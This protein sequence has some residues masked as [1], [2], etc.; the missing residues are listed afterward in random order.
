[1]ECL[2]T[3]WFSVVSCCCGNDVPSGTEYPETERTPLLREQT[4]P[5]E[6]PPITA[7]PSGAFGSTNTVS[8]PGS[9]ES[10]KQLTLRV[11][12]DDG[13]DSS[14]SNAASRDEQETLNEVVADCAV[15]IIDFSK[16]D[17][18]EIIV[19]RQEI[20]QRAVKYGKRLSGPTALAA[21]AGVL[22]GFPGV[23]EN[24]DTGIQSESSV[25]DED[26]EGDDAVPMPKNLIKA[27]SSNQQYQQ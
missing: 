20:Q 19:K 7:E 10:G 11:N 21:A 4:N 17:T 9:F 15:N 23:P 8:P 22:N 14:H 2:R 12:A 24:G 3:V 5:A 25:E 18:E 16:Q 6:A 27:I 1:M 13:S 26:E